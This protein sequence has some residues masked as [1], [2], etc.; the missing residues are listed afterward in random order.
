MTLSEKFARLAGVCW[1][2]NTENDPLYKNDKL[3]C[4]KCNTWQRI[5]PA[6]RRG[7]QHPD[8][9]DPREV[10]KVMMAREDWID[11]SLCVGIWDEVFN[12]TNPQESWYSIE[13]SYITEPNKL[14]KAAI[15]WLSKND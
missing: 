7:F 1:H 12:G 15:E 2:E 3:L 10:L 6:I 8:F 9:S 5:N 14:L 11:F 4:T 13:I